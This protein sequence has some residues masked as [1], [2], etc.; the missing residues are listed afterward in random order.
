[1]FPRERERERERREREGR[2]INE[3]QQNARSALMAEKA[4]DLGY[5]YNL[6]SL[7]KGV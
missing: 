7:Q 2:I 6:C 5:R 4:L 1:M 3:S